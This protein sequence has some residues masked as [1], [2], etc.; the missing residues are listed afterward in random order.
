MKVH[1]EKNTFLTFNIDFDKFEIYEIIISSI[2]KLFEAH[3]F[4]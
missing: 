3:G 4:L 2:L 1:K